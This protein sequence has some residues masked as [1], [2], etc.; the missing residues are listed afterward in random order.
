MLVGR[1]ASK[2]ALASKRLSAYQGD[3]L[4]SQTYVSTGLDPNGTEIG[5][6]HVRYKVPL[7]DMAGTTNADGEVV[8]LG[9]EAAEGAGEGEQESET[10][11][12]VSDVPDVMYFN[13]QAEA[14]HG[15]YWHNNFG[16]KMSHGCVNL[17]TLF[18]SLVVRLGAIGNAGLGLRVAPY[19]CGNWHYSLVTRWS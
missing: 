11:Y 9:E 19:R 1:N 13:L 17:P 12:T 18:L 14:L 4:I 16:N 6:F 7:Q 5:N 3:T 15:A 10:A 8:A 2:S